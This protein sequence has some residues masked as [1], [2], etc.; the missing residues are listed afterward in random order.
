MLQRAE[1]SDVVASDHE[2]HTPNCVTCRVAHLCLP[3]GTD[4]QDAALVA[5]L[6]SSRRRVAR[7]DH[8]YRVGDR[9]DNLFAV[10]RGQL[11]TTQMT[12]QGRPHVGAFVMTGEI[13]G[14]DGIANQRHEVD[15]V[16]LE[17][18][19]VCVIPY[20]RIASQHDVP[21]DVRRRVLKLLSREI[22]RRQHDILAL[23][24]LPA[25]ARVARFLRLQAIK[26]HERGY[27]S[28][29]IVLRMSRAEIGSHLGL[30]L[31]TVSRA[32]SRL[33]AEGV[34]DVD[35]RHIDIVDV[36]R[37]SLAATG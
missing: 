26:M 6:V 25:D 1:R 17:D 20:D 21:A 24:Q 32:I 3:A 13:L 27:S 7:G 23:G 29:S 9:F 16:A 36:Q 28:R 10:W 11:K 31:E 33:A 37:L 30:T 2:S 4:E 12:S 15:V 19:E 14:L 18:S 34:I 8:L 22:V 5:P 35:Q